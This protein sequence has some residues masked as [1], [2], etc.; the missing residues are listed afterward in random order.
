M[1]GVTRIVWSIGVVFGV[2]SGNPVGAQTIEQIA[3][4]AFAASM[5]HNDAT[6]RPVASDDGRWVAFAT[7]ARNLVELD[8]NGQRDVLLKDTISRN[9]QRLLG[10][11]Q[12]ERHATG[13]AHQIRCQRPLDG[14]R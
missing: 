6:Y 8:R 4:P 2:F 1:R 10:G 12:M 7:D 5:P 3:V 11:Q 14:G 13:W 9:L